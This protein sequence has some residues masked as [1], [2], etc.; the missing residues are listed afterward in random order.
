MHDCLITREEYEKGKKGVFLIVTATQ[1]IHRTE[2]KPVCASGK[3][4]N[5]P[6]FIKGA[7]MP[8]M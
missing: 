5:V 3:L 2:P 1:T 6:I 7:K 8:K 4:T